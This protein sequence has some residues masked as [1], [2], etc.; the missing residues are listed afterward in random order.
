MPSSHLLPP[1]LPR[2]PERP[3]RSTAESGQSAV[4]LAIMFLTLLAFVGLAT[5]A[6]ILYM[7]Y[8][9]LRRAA[10]A[11][12]LSAASQLRE[13]RPLDQITEAATQYVRLQNIPVG[14]GDVVVETCSDSVEPLGVIPNSKTHEKV[15]KD[16]S[17]CTYPVRKLVRVTV[18]ARVHRRWT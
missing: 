11:A 17:I 2:R 15:L 10:D 1:N 7:S 16:P 9:Q 4:I 13:A 8:G 14:A 12:A 3:R 5:D 6:G 18:T